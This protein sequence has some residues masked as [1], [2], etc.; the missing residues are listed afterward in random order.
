MNVAHFATVGESELRWLPNVGTILRRRRTEQLPFFAKHM[1]YEAKRLWLAFSRPNHAFCV[2]RCTKKTA[3]TESVCFVINL[4][5][6][7]KLG[8]AWRCSKGGTLGSTQCSV[9]AWYPL[10]LP[11][12]DK[13]IH[14][15]QT[16]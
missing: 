7:Y 2:R 3:H 1:Y 10:P 11:P 14:F 16:V 4:A 9:Q 12:N 5:Q 13:E 6:L 15:K 8:S